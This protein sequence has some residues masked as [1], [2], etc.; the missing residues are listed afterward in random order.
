MRRAIAA[1]LAVAALT[2]CSSDTRVERDGGVCYN[3]KES[4]IAGW[5][6]RT[7][8]TPAVTGTCDEVT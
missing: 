4:T 1:V 8:R 3:V 2:G 5:T 6:F 7:V